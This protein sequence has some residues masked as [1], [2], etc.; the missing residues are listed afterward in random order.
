M[1]HL[2]IFI[3]SKKNALLSPWKAPPPQGGSKTRFSYDSRSMEQATGGKS[4]DHTRNAEADSLAFWAFRDGKRR[5]TLC[6][7]K[8]LALKN[9]GAYIDSHTDTHIYIYIYIYI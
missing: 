6:C 7:W 9:M 1:F 4:E 3:F 2:L 8:M 5:Q